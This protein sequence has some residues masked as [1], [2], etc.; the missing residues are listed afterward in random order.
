M[1]LNADRKKKSCFPLSVKKNSSVRRKNPGPPPPQDIKW[2]VPKVE[3]VAIKTIPV[4]KTSFTVLKSIHEHVRKYHAVQ[5]WCH[6][7]ALFDPIRYLKG[8]RELSF[9]LHTCLHSRMNLPHHCYESGWTAKLGHDLQE[10][11]T[12]N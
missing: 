7:T 5:C 2:S 4:W 12:T 6:N 1:V 3:Y 9:I 8:F 10:S 11:I